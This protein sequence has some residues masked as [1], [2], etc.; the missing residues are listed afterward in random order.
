MTLT[1]SLVTP[2]LL[3]VMTAVPAPTPVTPP[4]RDTRATFGSLL[5]QRMARP[6]RASPSESSAS[7]PSEAVPPTASLS[8][9]GWT[10]SE[11]TGAG[12]A[13]G[14]AETVT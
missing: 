8:S 14:R 12:P 2:S 7:A 9:P 3:A 10:S 4:D 1:G 13:G 11:A 5:D 6:A